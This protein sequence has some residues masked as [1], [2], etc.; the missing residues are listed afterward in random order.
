MAS[1]CSPKPHCSQTLKMFR[2]RRVVIGPFLAAALWVLLYPMAAIAA[3]PTDDSQALSQ[4]LSQ[5]KSVA[6]SAP[7]QPTMSA[8]QAAALVRRQHG[9]RVLSVNSSRSGDTL[10]YKVRVL[11]D[12]GRVKTVYVRSGSV[13]SETKPQPRAS[14]RPSVRPSPRTSP[15]TSPRSSQRPPRRPEPRSGVRT[16]GDGQR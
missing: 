14:Q 1:M 12:G 11:V 8:A 15:R 10:G 9:G 7:P 13:K 16:I 5:T 6:Q 3:D 2:K 4:T